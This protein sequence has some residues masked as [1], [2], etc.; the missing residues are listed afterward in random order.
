MRASDLKVGDTVE[1]L[2]VTRIRTG[3]IQMRREGKIARAIYVYWSDG[4]W[5]QIHPDHPIELDPK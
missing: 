2:T 3:F 1:G 5:S 4:G